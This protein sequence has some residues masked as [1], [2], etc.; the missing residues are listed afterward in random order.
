MYR[1]PDGR[2]RERV[3]L[4]DGSRKEFKG[5]TKQEVL[6][7]IAKW[8]AEQEHGRP[9][10]EV[11]EEWWAQAEKTIAYNTAKSYVPAVRRACE[12]LG[13]KPI[14]DIKPPEINAQI[15]RMAQTYNIKTVKTQLLIY[16][17]VFR[18]AVAHGYADNNPAREIQAKGAPRRKVTMP[19]SADIKRVKKTV[20]LP[21]G[22]FAY[23]ALYT[24]LRRGEL[25]ALEWKDIDRKKHTIRVNKSLYHDKNRPIVKTTKTEASNSTLPILDALY[26]VLPPTRT[27]LVF[28]NA[29]GEHMSET[30]FQAAWAQYCQ[31]SGVTATP[32][33][34]RHAF[35]T[36]IFEA[37]IPAEQA[38]DLLRHAQYSTTRDVY[39]DLRNEHRLIVFEKIRGIN[40]S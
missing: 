38:K 2:Y 18:Y 4:P 1:K 27:G 9:F 31:A 32:H 37:G 40:I 17:H 25:L 22:L 21:F 15:E 26:N 24:G 34:F 29:K 19:S 23:M 14:K 39:T 5:R 13:D 7:K 3:T 16:N 11:A 28:P 20:D 12:A 35:A 10:K 30:Q 33:Q 8:S 36:M 6:Q